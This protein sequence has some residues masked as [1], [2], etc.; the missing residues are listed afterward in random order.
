MKK[1]YFIR[2]GLSEGNKSEIWSGRTD[3]SLAK[4]GRDQARAAGLKAR[5]LGIDLIVCSPLSRARETAEII[6]DQI[7]YPK[8]K[9]LVADILK[10]RN[11]G[12]LEGTPH[13]AFNHDKSD[14][15]SVPN[16]E[17]A[18][19]L[20]KRAEAALR[21]LESLDANNILVVSH[22]TFGRALRHHLLEDMPF[23]N[24]TGDI[25][26]RLPN[27]EIICWI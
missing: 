27:G 6:A 14:L 2:H 16:I 23:I 22:G 18:E 9:I 7:G 4:E 25:K 26:L 12:D 3:H 24:K 5:D 15:D 20:V 13:N 11:W 21:T 19:Q 1:L 17:T 8:D 10:E